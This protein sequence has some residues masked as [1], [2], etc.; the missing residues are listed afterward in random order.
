MINIATNGQSPKAINM[1]PITAASAAGFTACDQ[2]MGTAKT[3]TVSDAGRGAEGVLE[4]VGTAMGSGSATM[5]RICG[6]T[7]CGQNGRPS[8]TSWPHL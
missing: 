4:G 5:T 3:G 6:A 7:Q 1:A 2:V 8:S